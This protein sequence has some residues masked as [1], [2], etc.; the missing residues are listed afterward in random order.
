[1]L[2][3]VNV[4]ILAINREGGTAGSGFTEDYDRP[5]TDPDVDQ[6][7]G[8]A[9]WTGAADGYLIEKRQRLVTEAGRNL[10]KSRTVV[11]EPE[12]DV[13]EGDTLTWRRQRTGSVES[14][15]ILVIERPE[16]PGQQPI[17]R[18]SLEDV[19]G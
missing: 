19:P 13:A 8:E 11:I 14:G 3:Q 1:M 17:A 5:P 4:E 7:A 9:K 16:L 15:R 10:V 18:L 12:I 2:P 6:A